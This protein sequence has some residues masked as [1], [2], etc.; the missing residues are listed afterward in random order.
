[1]NFLP[2]GKKKGEAWEFSKKQYCFGSLGALDRKVFL[3]LFKA[4]Q[5]LKHIFADL[6]FFFFQ[7]ERNKLSLNANARVF[8][9]YNISKEI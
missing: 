1:M 2:E 6:E 4:V 8:P 9:A 5:L 3:Q 7:F